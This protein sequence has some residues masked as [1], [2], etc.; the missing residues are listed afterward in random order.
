MPS[1]T[2]HKNELKS[3]AIRALD[4][5]YE[6]NAPHDASGQPIKRER[7]S[8]LYMRMQMLGA[9]D[10]FMNT[11]LELHDEGKVRF[12]LPN[13]DDLE[14]M[15]VAVPNDVEIAKMGASLPDYR[16]L[17]P[18]RRNLFDRLFVELV[19]P[20]PP[21]VITPAIRDEL[22]ERAI[23]ELKQHPHKRERFARLYALMGMP[24]PWE[25]FMDVMLGLHADG[26]VHF[27]LNI[28]NQ[29]TTLAD[30]RALNADQQAR[31]DAEFVVLVRK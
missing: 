29:A 30:Y 23:D 5:V 12:N 9:W 19:Q 11:L 17:S 16:A 14:K 25:D 27:D 1:L 28:A 8:K 20:P 18:E 13:R 3:V 10:Q 7:F 26:R 6:P 21:V 2:I 22:N 4:S 24:V 15:G 31:F